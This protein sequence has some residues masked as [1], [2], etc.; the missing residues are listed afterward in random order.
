MLAQVLNIPRKFIKSLITNKVTAVFMTFLCTLIT[1][2]IYRISISGFGNFILTFALLL[3]G[4]L[5][6]RSKAFPENS[7]VVLNS[8]VIYVSL[9]ALVLLTVPKLDFSDNIALLMFMPWL[10]VLLSV[11]LLMLLHK[12]F[13]WDKQTFA[14]L[15]LLVPLGNTSFF[16]IPMV[17][18]YFGEQAVAYAVIYDQF[19]SFFALALYGSLILAIFDKNSKPFSLASVAHKIVT[20]PP[21][22]ALVVALLLSPFHLPEDY[23]TLLAPIAHTL[24]P[25]VMVAVGFQLHLRIDKK[26]LTPF[27][28]GLSIKMLVAPLFVVLLFSLFTIKGLIPQVIVFEAAMPPMIS[29]GALAIMA[30]FHPRL[31]SA[32]LAYGIL[33]AFI[34][35]PLVRAFTIGI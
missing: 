30:D 35:L 25:V 3:L 11:L 9:P 5:L 23:F 28:I 31:T 8:F 6:K 32:M 19:G 18:A 24:V 1:Y 20:F 22:I 7:A 2:T 15:L 34:T 13:H 17:Q 26:Y 16:G 29:A 33:L 4:F 10:I 14:V 12:F 27:M 21:F